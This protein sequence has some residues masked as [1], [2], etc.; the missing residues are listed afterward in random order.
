MTV[1]TGDP[2]SRAPG[3][4][5]V[6]E[7]DITKLLQAIA[8][9]GMRTPRCS[10]LRPTPTKKSGLTA[11]AF[12]LFDEVR[13]HEPVAM[14]TKK[15]ATNRQLD[16]SEGQVDIEDAMRRVHRG[17]SVA[18]LERPYLARLEEHERLRSPAVTAIAIVGNV[19]ALRQLLSAARL[20][21]TPEPTSDRWSCLRD[22]RRADDE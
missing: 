3:A 21:E 9:I 13:I 12:E 22:E 15:S 7:Q 11:I 18:C 14:H 4:R 1:P 2:S 6:S 16:G 5:S 19:S 10:G 20:S 8:T 17:Q